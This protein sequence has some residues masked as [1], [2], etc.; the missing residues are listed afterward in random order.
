M[1][2]G[3]ITIDSMY[4]SGTGIISSNHLFDTI[5]PKPYTEQCQFL[6]LNDNTVTS[7]ARKN[8]N[9]LYFNTTLMHSSAF[10]FYPK[11]II[12]ANQF[13]IKSQFIQ[14]RIWI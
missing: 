7:C 9:A 11:S 1:M 4:N 13:I 8:P 10:S 12:Y 2:C 14:S 3:Y 6:G 5:I